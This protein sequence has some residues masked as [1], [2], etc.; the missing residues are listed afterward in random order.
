MSQLAT[1][2]TGSSI[3]ADD[4]LRDIL[5]HIAVPIEVL[6]EAKGRRNLVLEIAMKHDAARASF[7]SGSI[8]HGTENSPLGDADCGL[9]VDRRFDAFRVFGPDA[10][11]GRGPEDFIVMFAEFVLPHLR[12]KYPEAE[13]NLEGNRAIKFELNEPIE[14]GEWGAVD[15][16]VELIVGLERRDGP[17][18]WIPNRR[19]DG[20]DPADP[21]HHT[22]LMTERDP[23]SLRV[24]RAHLIRLGKR[25]VKRD[26][27]VEGRLQ[28]MCSW[29]LSALGLELVDQRRSITE[30]LLAYL[31][32]SAI[33]IG[34]SLTEDPAEA[35]EDPITLPDGVTKEHA[36]A[37][38]F[39]M[40]DIVEEAMHAVSTGGARGHLERL[41]GPEIAT[42]RARESSHL[43]S[44]LAAGDGGALAGALGLPD[45]Q[46][47]T[48]SHGPR[49]T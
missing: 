37:R 21:E 8:A 14:F 20:W 18:I 29:N 22:F 17:G 47:V 28:V 30:G 34:A 38:L 39:E 41:F 44:A 25:A 19:E 5:K 46:K 35:V 32:G 40:A 1:Q 9:K 43:K 23:R 33:S 4:V 27:E 6:R 2:S 45:A 15:P 16:F 13:V 49:A 42:I 48:R 12:T 31:R 26:K 3:P 24:H 10:P 7:Y 36:S 11:E